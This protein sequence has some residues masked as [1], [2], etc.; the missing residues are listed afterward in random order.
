MLVKEGQTKED[1]G[2]LQTMLA[3]AVGGLVF[4]TLTYPVDVAKSRIQVNNQSENFIVVG[5]Q[6][7]KKEGFKAL[8]HGLTPTLVRTIPATATLFVAYE[9]TKRFLNH[10]F[11]DY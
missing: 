9:Y 10:V 8:Y 3:G 4:W 11:R 5:I 2:L 1:L 6:I 7:M